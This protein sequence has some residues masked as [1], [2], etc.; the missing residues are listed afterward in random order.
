MPEKIKNLPKKPRKG[1]KPDK[2]KN[3]IIRKI[4]INLFFIKLN[5]EI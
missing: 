3:K 5:S 4:I 1:G 2:E